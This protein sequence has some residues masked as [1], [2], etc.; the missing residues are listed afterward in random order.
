MRG[1]D[2]SDRAITAEREL[3]FAR[4]QLSTWS[5]EAAAA[6]AQLQE[7]LSELQQTAAEAADQAGEAQLAL[8]AREKLCSELQADL[9]SVTDKVQAGTRLTVTHSHSISGHR[10]ATRP[11]QQPMQPSWCCRSLA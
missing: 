11:C 1:S 6:Q 10:I 2:L 9:K 3:M 4:E 7:Q 8:Q 5:A